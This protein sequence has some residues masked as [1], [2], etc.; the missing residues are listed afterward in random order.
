MADSGAMNQI[1]ALPSIKP[2]RGPDDTHP[3]RGTFVDRST[4]QLQPLG[5]IPELSSAPLGWDGYLVEEHRM[6]P[7]E[8]REVIWVRDVVLVQQDKPVTVHFKEGRKYVRRR[9]LPG[10]VSLRPARSRTAARCPE[11]ARVLM[12]ALDPGFLSTVCP[13]A[14]STD[15]LDLPLRFG[16]EDR[17]VEGVC[18]A[19]RDEVAR[20]GTSGRL[21]SDSLA[22]SLAVHLARRYTPDRTRKACPQDKLSPRKVRLAMEYIHDPLNRDLNLKDIAAAVGL[23]PFH[24]SR[25]FKRSTGLTPHQYVIRQRVE[26]ARQLLLRGEL[27]PA[28]IAEKV[29]FCDQSHMTMHFKRVCGLTPR[30]FVRETVAGT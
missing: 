1:G 21:Y 6:P 15:G 28:A 4:G 18:T 29:G 12:V 7:S 16:I 24:F 25:L 19:L 5:G 30:A 13:E 20:G 9:L 11:P 23:S 27:S 17:F 22:M 26:L 14:V 3:F 2:T 10:R 8:P